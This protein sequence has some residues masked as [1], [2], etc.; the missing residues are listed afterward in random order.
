M[1]IVIERFWTPMICTELGTDNVLVFETEE[2]A[3]DYADNECQNG[4]AVYIN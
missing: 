4:T 1:W 3:K 2:D